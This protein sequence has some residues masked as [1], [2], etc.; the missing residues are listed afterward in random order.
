[1]LIILC[2]LVLDVVAVI[3]Y[4]CVVF[5]ATVTPLDV[6]VA[7]FIVLMDVVVVVFVVFIDIFDVVVILDIGVD[8]YLR[9]CALNVVLSVT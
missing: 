9:A 4:M 2:A 1:M 6:V 5:G 7:V 8:V 3:V